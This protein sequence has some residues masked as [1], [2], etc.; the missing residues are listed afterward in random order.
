[1][2]VNAMTSDDHILG[3]PTGTRDTHTHPHIQTHTHKYFAMYKQYVCVCVCASAYMRLI[4]FNLRRRTENSC[5]RGWPLKGE[6]RKK[7]ERPG[8]KGTK[9]PEE[10]LVGPFMYIL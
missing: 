6:E 7:V 2:D 3:S 8:R 10:P 4:R 9:R 1:M 5:T